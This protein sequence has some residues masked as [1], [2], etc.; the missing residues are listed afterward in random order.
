MTVMRR[1]RTLGKADYEALAAFR[2]ALRRF[3]AFS[4]EAAHDAG[5][6]PQQHQALL[7]IKGNPGADAMSVG[8]IARSL[9]L[10]PHSALELVNRLADL[11]LVVRTTDPADHRRVQVELTERAEAMLHALS[12]AHLEEIRSIRPTLRGLLAL[13]GPDE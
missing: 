11:D 3:A 7:A 9:L 8:E 5:L 12:A 10:K 4:A 1:G 6:T 2:H 13:F